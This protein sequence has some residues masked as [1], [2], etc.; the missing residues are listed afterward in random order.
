[1]LS[2]P[3]GLTNPFHHDKND[4]FDFLSPIMEIDLEELCAGF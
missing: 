4:A 3:S 2:A 1:L